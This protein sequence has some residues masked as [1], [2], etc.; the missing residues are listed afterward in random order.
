MGSLSLDSYSAIPRVGGLL[1]SPDGRRLVMTV[2]TLSPDGT[3][4]V[5]SLWEMPSDGSSPAR[6]ITYS[7]RGETSPAYLPDGSLVFASARPDPTVKKDEAGGHLWLLPAAGGEARPVL[8]LPGGAEAAVAAAQ[9]G[10]VALR[11]PMLPGAAGLEEDEE[12]GRRRKESGVTGI[13]FD[14]YP[15]RFWDHALGP[16]QARLLRVTGLD[17]DRPTVEDVTGPAG[18]AVHDAEMALSPDGGTVYTT[19]IRATGGTFQEVDLAAIDRS[20]CRRL[21]GDRDFHEPAVSP[22]GTRV[23]AVAVRRPTPELAQDR[24]LWLF[25]LGTGE[26]RDIAPELDLWPQ[27]PAWSRDGSSVVFTADERGHTPLYRLD[28]QSGE[29]RR[30]T[31]AGAFASPCPAPDGSI[32]ALRSSYSSPSEVVR[33]APDGSVT[34]LPSPGLPLELPGTVTEVT[35]TADDGSE[36]RAWL[37]L[38]R[39]ASAERPAPLLLWIH[40]GPL[41]SW[42]SW[43]WRWNPHLMAERGYAV[44]LPDPALSTGYGHANIQRGSASWGERVFADLMAV[45]DRALERPD[46]DASRTAAMG[47]SFGGYMAN[48]VAGHTDRFRAIVSHAGLWA[49]D[50]FHATTDLSSY[51]ERQHGDPDSQ[52]E[53]YARLS[54]RTSVKAVRTPMLVIHGERDYRVPISEALRLWTDLQRRGVPSQYLHFP[55]ENHWI[56]TPGNARAWYETVLAFLDHHVAGK[57]LE[58]PALL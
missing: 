25:D 57:P 52:P 56:L 14:S 28:V 21:P 41:S 45:T 10:A 31:G 37:V 47:G 32:F 29:I 23:A 34:A 16:R 39:D 43:S 50:Q 1:L 35:G 7:E 18:V 6:R 19:W 15:I 13:L 4:F 8:A 5:T 11:V 48:W 36:V 27:S 12:L 53:R 20:G 51:W 2:Q 49:L 22:D 24:T 42:C 40:G 3:R 55:D 54:P 17:A 44:L 58:R 33:V 26:G 38:P 30:L 9:A 46:L